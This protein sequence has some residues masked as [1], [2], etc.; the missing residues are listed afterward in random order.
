MQEAVITN[1]LNIAQTF[2]IVI[3]KV[4]FKGDL[5]KGGH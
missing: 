5:N 1:S 4:L 2:K 3:Q